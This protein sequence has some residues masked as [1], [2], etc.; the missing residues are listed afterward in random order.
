MDHS[1]LLQKMETM[2]W[3]GPTKLV[4]NKESKD[5]RLYIDG[6]R[7]FWKPHTEYIKQ[8]LSKAFTILCKT[9]DLLNKK[10]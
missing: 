6:C 2:V 10:V 3:G 1:I 5:C 4:K 8:N 7:R 9:K